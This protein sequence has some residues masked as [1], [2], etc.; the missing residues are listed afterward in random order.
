[1]VAA[2]AKVLTPAAARRGERTRH[3]TFSSASKRARIAPME[4]ILAAAGGGLLLL[5]VAGGIK[6]IKT[7]KIE[8]DEFVP[9]GD[10]A[11]AILIGAA[12]I[13][14]A[15]VLE[16]GL[17]GDWLWATLA[18]GGIVVL[19]YAGFLLYWYWEEKKTPGQVQAV[20]E[21]LEERRG[22]GGEMPDVSIESTEKGW[23][24]RLDLGPQS[25]SREEFVELGSGTPEWIVLDAGVTE[26]GYNAWTVECGPGHLARA[27]SMIRRETTSA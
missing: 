23:M 18:F 20:I 4:A 2:S 7:D 8:K 24:L 3:A 10:R 13:G 15:A 17:R 22:R 5:G 16:A 19:L 21:W 1:V 26:D 11:A 14:L 12:L 6:R 9:L 27:L 25:P